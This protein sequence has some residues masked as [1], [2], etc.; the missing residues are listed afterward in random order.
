[1]YRMRA[2]PFSRLWMMLAGLV[3]TRWKSHSGKP[4]QHVQSMK[5]SLV[6]LRLDFLS[7]RDDFQGRASS[8]LKP[9]R[10]CCLADPGPWRLHGTVSTRHRLRRGPTRPMR[11]LAAAPSRP[12]DSMGGTFTDHWTRSRNL[13]YNSPRLVKNEHWSSFFL[14]GVY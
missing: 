2:K 13:E 11:L 5:G 14:D 10:G 7:G 9:I 1:M 8:S 3:F 4:A 12:R 6:P